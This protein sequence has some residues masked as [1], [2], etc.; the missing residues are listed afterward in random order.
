MPRSTKDRSTYEEA[1]SLRDDKSSS[2]DVGG[3]PLTPRKDNAANSGRKT[4][5]QTPIHS[6]SYLRSLLE[7]AP[8]A[9]LTVDGGGR[10][11]FLNAQA[12]HMFGYSRE[13]LLSMQVDALVPDHHRARH[14]AHR[15][16]YRHRP[17]LRPMGGGL[18]LKGRR[19]DGTIF[20]V[21][22][23]LSP[24]VS[25]GEHLV[26]AFIRDVSERKRIEAAQMRA[27]AAEQAVRQRDEFLSVA[28]HELKTPLTSLLGFAE[29]LGRLYERGR[30]PET[31]LL[32][33]ALQ[34]IARQSQKI[35]GLV[36]QLLDVSRIEAGRLQIE[37]K[38]TDLISIIRAVVA[39]A[40]ARTTAHTFIVRTPDS[41]IGNVDSLRL[42]QVITNLID[43]AVKY[44]PDGGE[45]AISVSQNADRLAQIS[46]RDHGIGIPEAERVH[47]FDRYYQAHSGAHRSGMGLGLYISRQIVELHGGRMEAEFPLDGGTEI[48][49]SLPLEA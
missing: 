32:R 41:M 14:A 24:F 37:R 13:E 10:V 44:S 21:E 31:E 3:S 22:I 17:R 39:D 35:N 38:Q 16:S 26:T 20:P 47:I 42:E 49:I 2:D 6:E 30:V 28:A 36:N 8:D 29:A 48:R 34:T 11:V 4:A 1:Q 43:N 40:Q 12:V 46:V 19:K 23:S 15:E 45:I 18:D 7:S 25:D 27:E 33:Q 9:V 5:E